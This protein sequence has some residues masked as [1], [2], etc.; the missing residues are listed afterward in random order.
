MRA[1]YPN[2]QGVSPISHSITR[3]RSGLFTARKSRNQ[4]RNRIRPLEILEQRTLLTGSPANTWYV[5]ASYAFDPSGALGSST[6]PFASIKDAVNAANVDSVGPDTVVIEDSSQYYDSNIKINVPMTIEGSGGQDPVLQGSGN[7]KAGFVVKASGVQISGLTIEGFT[8][9]SSGTTYSAGIE[10]TTGGSVAIGSNTITGNSF[11]VVV[12]QGGTAA[13]T[14]NAI[15]ANSVG[16]QVGYTSSDTSTASINDNDLTGNTSQAG[17]ER[18]NR[19]GGRRLGQLLGKLGSDDR[20]YRGRAQ[21]GLHAV[22][23]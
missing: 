4:L 7:S 11:G 12:E 21:R 2:L 8:G 23:Q 10:V 17:G 14:Y 5:D 3:Q 18:G 9:T 19:H 13:I 22:P 1:N 16:V 20:R 15:T 6:N